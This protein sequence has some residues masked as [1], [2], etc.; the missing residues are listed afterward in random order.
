MFQHYFLY[1]LYQEVSEDE[2]IDD[3]FD[4]NMDESDEIEEL[5]CRYQ[6][7][8]QEKRLKWTPMRTQT[9]EKRWTTWKQSQRTTHTGE[10][11]EV[12]TNNTTHC[13]YFTDNH[14]TTVTIIITH[15]Y[16]LQTLQEHHW[17]YGRKAGH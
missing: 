11:L 4:G 5:Q 8:K 15:L 7:N 14:T 2:Q 9:L 1:L 17:K 13:N 3:D 16:L 10:Q 12:E 6:K